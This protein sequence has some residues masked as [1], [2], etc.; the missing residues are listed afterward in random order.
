M[1]DDPIRPGARDRYLSVVIDRKDGGKVVAGPYRR[2][3]DA[4][5]ARTRLRQS[6]HKGELWIAT[7]EE[8]RLGVISYGD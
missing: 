1:T 7:A 5:A 6:R 2:F 8:V 4:K 3:Q